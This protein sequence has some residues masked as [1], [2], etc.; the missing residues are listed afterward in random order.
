MSAMLALMAFVL[1][2]LV[3]KV[4]VG[5]YGG[6]T[7]FATGLIGSVAALAFLLFAAKVYFS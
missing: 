1:I 2:L 7:R 6:E 3:F 5:G 4:Q